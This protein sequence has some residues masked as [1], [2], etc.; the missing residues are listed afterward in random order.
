M[1][2]CVS[3]QGFILPD[4]VSPC[5][6]EWMKVVVEDWRIM[7]IIDWEKAIV[8]ENRNINLHRKLA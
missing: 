7:I 3:S 2:R 8:G 5:R 4:L 6:A 1:S